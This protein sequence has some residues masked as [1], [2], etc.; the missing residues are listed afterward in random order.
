MPKVYGNR[1]LL[2]ELFNN[3]FSNAVKYNKGDEPR[4]VIDWEDRGEEYLVKFSDNGP[5]IKERYLE[6][7][8]QVFEK[9]N[10]RED[11]EGIGIGL[12][13]CKRIIDEHGGEIWAE[14]DLGEGTTFLFTLPA[15]SP[16]T[17]NF[18]S[19][20]KESEEQESLKTKSR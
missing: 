5:G 9:L 11:P 15:E 4:I 18:P 3:L 6:K 16:I 14:S 2:I 20:E 19:Q 17:E 1:T 13:L 7:I 12:A 8:F 10:P